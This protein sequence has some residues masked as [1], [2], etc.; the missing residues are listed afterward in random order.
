MVEFGM[1]YRIEP[2]RRFIDPQLKQKPH[3]FLTHATRFRMLA[4]VTRRQAVTQPALGPRDQAD[5]VCAETY[6]LVQFTVQRLFGGFPDVDPALRKLPAAIAHAARPQHIA[7][8]ARDDHPDI[9]T[10]TID[11]NGFGNTFHGAF[12]SRIHYPAVYAIRAAAPEWPHARPA[13]R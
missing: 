12:Y 8:L 5:V 3:L 4:L 7:V 13:I 6:F 2:D 11:I 1:V 9:G 10:K